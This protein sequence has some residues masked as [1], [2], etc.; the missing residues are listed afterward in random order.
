MAT[1]FFIPESPYWLV[2]KGKIDKAGRTLTRLSNK[3][4]D[5]GAALQQIIALN[6][7]E[8]FNRAEAKDTRF[9]DCFKG[10]N[11]RRTRIILYCNGLSQVLGASFSA[12][13]PYFLVQA[14]MSAERVSMIIELGI[15][16]GI[17]SSIIAG[18]LMA[19]FGRIPLIQA[20]LVVS[21]IFFLMMGVAGCFP[22][23]TAALW[24][25]FSQG[26]EK[27]LADLQ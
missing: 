14:G 17:A 12:N 7:E 27:Y 21:T 25:V 18:F 2:G 9:V 1:I 5:T 10:T 3:E 26:L 6:E 15:A 24:S 23:N 4:T 16:F 8:R 13:G 11:W 20:G 22:N 19:R